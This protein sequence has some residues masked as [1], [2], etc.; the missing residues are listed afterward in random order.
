M[1]MWNCVSWMINGIGF[2]LIPTVVIF[3]NLAGAL[4]LAVWLWTIMTTAKLIIWLNCV[5]GPLVSNS[6]W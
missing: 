2:I 4:S 6:R 1:E 3:V 5:V